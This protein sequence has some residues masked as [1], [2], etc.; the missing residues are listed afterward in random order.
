MKKFAAFLIAALFASSACAADASHT[1]GTVDS[2]D[3]KLLVLS[4]RSRFNQTA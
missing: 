2:R 3:T 1:I 4:S